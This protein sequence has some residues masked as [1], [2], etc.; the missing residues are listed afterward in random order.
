MGSPSATSARPHP[1]APCSGSRSR[2]PANRPTGNKGTIL[3]GQICR[4]P[5]RLRSILAIRPRAAGVHIPSSNQAAAPASGIFKRSL[6]T[7]PS[8]RARTNSPRGRLRCDRFRKH[9]NRSKK[10]GR[11]GR[12][13][14]APPG[15]DCRCLRLRSGYSQR[16]RRLLRLAQESTGRSFVASV[17]ALVVLENYYGDPGAGRPPPFAAHRPT[18]RILEPRPGST[19]LYSNN[20]PICF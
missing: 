12:R 5:P 8:V 7:V 3:I 16:R 10:R 11:T 6:K 17:L 19:T 20:S 1:S 9:R 18:S 4:I 14:C 15:E 13:S 2:S